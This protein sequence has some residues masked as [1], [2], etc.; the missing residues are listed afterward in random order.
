[1]FGKDGINACTI[2]YTVAEYKNGSVFKTK[3]KNI[4]QKFRI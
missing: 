3:N 2:K 1:M 4:T